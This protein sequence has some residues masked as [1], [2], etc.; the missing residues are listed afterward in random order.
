ME[1]EEGDRCFREGRFD[2]AIVHYTL[3]LSIE[4][5]AA[6]YSNRSLVHLKLGAFPE[7]LADTNKCIELDNKFTRAYYRAAH[8]SLKLEK[9]EGCINY[10]RSGLK[11]GPPVKMDS[12]AEDLKCFADLEVTKTKTNF[13]NL[14]E[15]F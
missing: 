5:S 1:K 6:V 7:S 8:A 2:D 14:I 4:E 13:T 3:S 12:L 11:A 9:I 15:I 10:I